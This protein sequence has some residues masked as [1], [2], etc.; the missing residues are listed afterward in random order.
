M[1]SSLD[2]RLLVHRAEQDLNQWLAQHST[3]LSS[4]AIS[5]ESQGMVISLMQIGYAMKTQLH[6]L[7]EQFAQDVWEERLA[8]ECDND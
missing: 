2:A 5:P 6:A 3:S 1:S 4:E 8:R 7:A